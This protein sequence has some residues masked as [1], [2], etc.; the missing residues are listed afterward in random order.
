MLSLSNEGRRKGFLQG[1]RSEEGT[2]EDPV[3][4]ELT[5]FVLWC[6]VS[7]SLLDHF[8]PEIKTTFA[9][10]DFLRQMDPP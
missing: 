4:P 6:L 3:C 2:T 1:L 7:D 10:Q 5:R 8:S 9:S